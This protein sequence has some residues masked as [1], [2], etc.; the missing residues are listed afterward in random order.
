MIQIQIQLW[1]LIYIYIILYTIIRIRIFVDFIKNYI[2][3][4]Y[5]TYGFAIHF[6]L[7]ELSKGYL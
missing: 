6:K 2:F 3:L 1:F 4:I 7:I 5:N